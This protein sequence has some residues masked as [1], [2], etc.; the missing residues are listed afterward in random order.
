MFISFSPLDSMEWTI[1]CTTL[2]FI[3]VC[4]LQYGILFLFRLHSIY[5]IVDNWIEIY[6]A[7]ANFNLKKYSFWL[8]PI[9]K[10]KLYACNMWHKDVIKTLNRIILE[11][12]TNSTEWDHLRFLLTYQLKYLRVYKKQY[13]PDQIISIVFVLLFLTGCVYVCVS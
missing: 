12:E 11:R 7:S 10:C 6:N 4:R 2:S 5:F 13:P 3:M 8:K 9:E 1:Y